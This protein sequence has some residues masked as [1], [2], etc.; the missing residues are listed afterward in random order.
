M[1]VSLEIVLQLS[2]CTRQYLGRARG[3]SLGFSGC[4][5]LFLSVALKK[6]VYLCF[7]AD[8]APCEQFLDIPVSLMS[9]GLFLL[10]TILAS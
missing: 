9:A 3:A 2:E 10:E 1:L 6:P 7:S 4:L 5:M 8:G